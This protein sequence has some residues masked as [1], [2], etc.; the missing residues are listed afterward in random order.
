MAIRAD[1]T[2]SPFLE[3]VRE[4]APQ[5]EASA[6]ESEQNRRL[7]MAL[8]EAMAQA[9]LF[10]LW[11]PR[12]LGG[13]EVD[14]ATGVQVIEAVSR[15]DGATGWCLAI[16]S[17]TSLLSGYL[18]SEAAREIYA[19]DPD[20]VTAGAWPPFGEA[21]VAPG[22]YRASGRWPFASGCHHS[23]WIQGGCRIVDGDQARLREDGTPVVRVL[24]FPATSCEIL[25]TWYTAG[26]R[27][28]GSHDFTVND[29][30]V[31]AAHAVSFREPPVEPGPLYA[32]PTIALSGT[33]IAAVALGIARHAIDILSAVARSKVAMRSQRVLSQH[34]VLQS[35]LGRAE[36]LL[37]SGRALLYQTIEEAWQAVAADGTLGIVHR[38]TLFLA[39]T[40]ATQA[41]AQVVDLMYT[42]GG[43]ASIYAHTGLERCLR[44]VR[45]VSHHI[46]V[47]AGNYEMVGQALL[48]FDMR[49]TPLLRMDDRSAE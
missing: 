46:A 25:D 23:G 14:V 30:F 40:Q 20:I 36:G 2:A 45:T 19:G 32:L 1:R 33:A 37:R 43:S 18:P 10:R 6:D 9:G 34:A 49:M 11:R 7:P 13:D 17:N 44:D 35:D 15:I 29:I 42:A 41:A 47:A 26:L 31:P 12:S 38:A 39:S 28:T 3:A 22:G 5:I 8:V 16:G 4:L 48:G 21:V 24:F 27:G